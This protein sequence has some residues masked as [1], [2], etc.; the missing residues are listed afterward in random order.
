LVVGR[1]SFGK[2]LVQEPFDLSDGSAL[3]LTVS[4][5]YTPSG[6]CIQKDYKIHGYDEY[7]NDIYARIENGELEDASKQK[8]YDSTEYRTKLNNRI[9]YGGGGIYPDVFVPID[10]SYNT[11]FLSEVFANG[12]LNKFAYDYLDKNRNS[13][14]AINNLELYIKSY[15]I[16]DQAFNLFIDFCKQQSISSLNPSDINRSKNFVKLQLKALIARQIWREKGYYNVVSKQDKGVLK[17][18]E[19]LGK[20]SQLMYKK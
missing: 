13:I 16:T 18:I 6:R 1:R 14:M 20:Y 7:E 8:I 12:L 2:G 5:Y 15:Q 3:R 11:R 9:V 19:S 10:T 17:A 4:R